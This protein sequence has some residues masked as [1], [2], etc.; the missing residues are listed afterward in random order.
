MGC[1]C[2]QDLLG[3]ALLYGCQLL[4]LQSGSPCKKLTQLPK[5]PQA[6]IYM[7]RPS[8]PNPLS[9]WE[10]TTPNGTPDRPPLACGVS[11]RVLGSI[12]YLLW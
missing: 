4:T 1:L 6:A 7:E 3:P 9:M 8:C 5:T 2:L 11:P 12:A 10:A